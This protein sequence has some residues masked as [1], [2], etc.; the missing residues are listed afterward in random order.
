M[1]QWQDAARLFA[2]AQP[3]GKTVH[4]P[5]IDRAGPAIRPGAYARYGCRQGKELSDGPERHDRPFG[6]MPDTASVT[7]GT[8]RLESFRAASTSLKSE[9]FLTLEPGV[10]SAALRGGIRI[11]DNFALREHGLENCFSFVPRDL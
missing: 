1:Q 10:Y 7:A 8:K 4:R 3:G 2:G 11:E 6:I 5:A 9:A